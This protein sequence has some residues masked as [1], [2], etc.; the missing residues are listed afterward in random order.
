MVGT[1]TTFAKTTTTRE[2]SFSALLCHHITLPREQRRPLWGEEP[3]A[4]IT[5]QIE[6]A[7][8]AKRFLHFGQA[9][10]YDRS[11]HNDIT[12]SLWD[13][14]GR[15]TVLTF[16]LKA[17][18]IRYR[19]LSTPDTKEKD[20][21]AIY[22]WEQ[23]ICSDSFNDLEESQQLRIEQFP[24]R[25]EDNIPKILYNHKDD[26]EAM[27]DVMNGYLPLD[28]FQSMAGQHTCEKCDRTFNNNAQFMAHIEKDHS[29]KKDRYKDTS[30]KIYKMM[31]YVYGW[32]RDKY[33]GQK[34]LRSLADYLINMV[35]ITE[36][37]CQDEAECR[38][39]MAALNT[40]GLRMEQFTL[41]RCD[42]LARLT[43]EECEKVA[44]KWDAVYGATPDH[45]KGYSSKAPF[46]KNIMQAALRMHNKDISN[47]K[48]IYAQF[49]TILESANPREYINDYFTICDKYI[50]LFKR[51]PSDRFGR[52][53]LP[54]SQGLGVPW[55]GLENLLLPVM[56]INKKAGEAILEMFGKWWA[57]TLGTQPDKFG[58]FS[59]ITPMRQ[60]AQKFIHA[61][62][63]KEHTSIL[64]TEVRKLLNE[65]CLSSND[66][67]KKNKERLLKPKAPST[68]RL[69]STLETV[70][71]TKE[72]T[73][74]L[75]MDLEHIWPTNRANELS[76]PEMVNWLGNLTLFEKGNNKA[77]KFQGNRGSQDMVKNKMKHYKTS[78]SALTKRIPDE[79]PRFFDSPQEAEA[80]IRTRD[81]AL[82]GQLDTHTSLD[83]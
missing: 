77:L 15:L 32:V 68:K 25:Y 44:E 22:K 74:S 39:K 30:S 65:N 18:C 48:D 37:T 13:A 58:K 82:W 83:K 76:N 46:G 75:K 47:S 69:L 31:D 40:T 60:M 71:T 59:Y 45:A 12:R 2:V 53:L 79:Y 3:I 28:C 5:D 35:E 6:E 49:Q 17:V 24:E 21:K 72:H 29:Y 27:K 64:L 70:T 42:L 10:I 81:A 20:T 4:S 62:D 52:L 56:H 54:H 16:A 38:R 36:V 34:D 41:I 61:E 67:I 57:R 7:H 14:Q 73:T 26:R 63:E 78:A 50:D 66:Y 51:I 1:R 11:A 33:T 9:L 43:K 55:E 19:A 23:V 80:A 8:E